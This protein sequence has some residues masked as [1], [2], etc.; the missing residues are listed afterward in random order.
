MQI[1]SKTSQNGTGAENGPPFIGT[2]AGSPLT[3]CGTTWCGEA[4]APWW[5]NCPFLTWITLRSQ[6]YGLA[7]GYQYVLGTCCWHSNP[8]RPLS[9]AYNRNC[10]YKSPWY[11]KLVKLSEGLLIF[12]WIVSH[13]SLFFLSYHSFV[14][15]EITSPN[16]LLIHTC[17]CPNSS[18]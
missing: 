17:Y 11:F 1:S 3:L 2:E 14:D 8:R 12:P 4:V 7:P 9:I 13:P 6:E 5:K 18:I 16:Q 15:L 10:P